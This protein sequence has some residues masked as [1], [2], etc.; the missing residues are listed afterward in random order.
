MIRKEE[1]AHPSPLYTLRLP[2]QELDPLGVANIAVFDYPDILKSIFPGIREQPC[3]H[4]DLDPGIAP[5]LDGHVL[6]LEGRK[7]VVVR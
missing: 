6:T 3:T 7:G 2:G 5:A 1:K 4:F